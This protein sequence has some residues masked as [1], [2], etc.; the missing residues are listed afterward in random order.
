MFKNYLK[1]AFRNLL[2]NR[3]HS[4]I[5]ISG[6]ATG[7]AVAML[8]GLWIWDE[9]SFDKNHKN[10]S[11]IAQVQ[12]HLVNNG[13]L[14]TWSN[15]PYPLA[16]ELRTNYDSDFKAIAMAA[17]SGNHIL[18]AGEKKLSIEGTYFEP[19]APEMLS[20]DMLKGDWNAL[21]DPTSI[22]LAKSAAKA[23]FGDADPMGKLMKIDNRIDVKVTGIYDDLPANATFSSV[24]F[25]APW[26]LYF[27]NTEWVRTASDP[28][29]PNA[30]QLFV[31]L[32]DNAG[33]ANVSEKIR[34]VRLKKV[35]KELAKKK[36]QLF[37]HPMSKWH[38]YSEFEN[39]VNTGG[40]I[41]YVWM[42]GIIGV[43]VLL[44][45]CINFMNL[46]TA[47]SEKRAREVGI[48]KAVGSLRG[49]LIFRF[50]SESLLV[51]AF[52]LI[53]ALLLVQLLLPFFNQL[54]DK[55][56]SVLW[57]NPWF[58]M[59]C[60]AFSFFT[61]LVAGSYPA[62]YL[63][64][65]RPVKILKGTF[66]AGRFAAVPRRVLV[67]LQFA[68]S[69][70]MIIGTVIVFRQ[71]QYTKN[72]PIGYN[73]NGL[74]AIPTINDNIHKHFDAVKSELT[75][76]GAIQSMAETASP[77][78]ETWSSS[79]G[80]DWKGKDPNLSVDFPRVDVSYDYGQTIG[81]EITAG[82]DFSRQ[83]ATDSS[84]LILNEAAVK[85]MGLQNPIGETV[86]WFGDPYTVIGVVKD[87]I[88]QNPYAPVRPT[89][90]NLYQGNQNFVILR[91]DPSANGHTAIAEIGKTFRKFNPE[92]PFEYQ[93]ADD[94]YAKKFGNEV[95]L[96]K[97]AGFFAVLAIFISCLGLF[98]MAAFMAEQRTREIGVRKVLG[99]SIF[100]LWRL[101]SKEFVVLIT[102]SL[103]IA[104]PTAYYLMHD[105][106]Q[107]YEYRSAISWWIF[108]A[109][110][111]GAMII[112]LM[113]VSYQSLKA[114]LANPVKSLRT[115]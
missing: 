35:N 96:G 114:S 15:V 77:T 47:R 67:V 53:M 27:A 109:A 102:I 88:M 16:E 17:G 21:K 93:F 58:W 6:L 46:S 113:T 86:R 57:G 59:A 20:L 37:L 24:K 107:N 28:W 60:A 66:K 84:A 106:L 115:E 94:E 10:Y 62:F 91:I 50:F 55:K 95:R 56:M 29:R 30:F 108:A 18:S 41:R 33:F 83:F 48:R 81:W 31:Q 26:T 99:A 71:I 63:S 25:I 98:G 13:Q 34:D 78:T 82:R 42:F 22:L 5:N 51:T 70:T 45:A 92:Q 11:R 39:G 69:I 65:F 87:V 75:R 32:R 23:F 97:L 111:S 1:T 74:V 104:I 72:R 100:N 85:F 36:P 79:S 110:G 38:L 4:I 3:S 73:N 49:Q 8:I 2:K 40:R 54:A 12:Q 68:V 64:S 61:G 43:F 89:V 19:A 52:S 14:G 90:F 44:L 80:F 105:W 9:L 103:I 112:A 101:L 7:M 76:T